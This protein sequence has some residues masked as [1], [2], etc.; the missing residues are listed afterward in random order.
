MASKASGA[1][2]GNV[3]ETSTQTKSLQTRSQKAGL[4]VCRVFLPSGGA[5]FCVHLLMNNLLPAYLNSPFFRI[6]LIVSCVP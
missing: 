1:K 2:S 6:L 3:G 4:Q 5:I